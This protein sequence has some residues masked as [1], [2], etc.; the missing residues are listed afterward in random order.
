MNKMNPVVHFEMPAED[1][2]RMKNFYEKAFGWQTNQLGDEMGGYVQVTTTETGSDMRPTQPGTINGGFYQKTKPDQ[3]PGVVIAV[4]N[5]EEAM[6]QV[7]A[8]GG[9]I[10]GGRTPGQPDDIPGI[11]LYCSFLDTEGNRVSM[12]QPKR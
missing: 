10:L 11:G 9:T 1:R 8:A 3:Y 4:E 7:A 12:L 2:A 6:K 5:M